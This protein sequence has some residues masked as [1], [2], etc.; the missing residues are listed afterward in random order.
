MQRADL[1]ITREW[2]RTIVWRLAMSQALL[3]SRSSKE[4]LSLLFPVRLS[5]NLRHQVTKMSRHDI[6]VHGSSMTQKLFEITDT[7]A[8]VLIHVPAASLEETALRIEDYLFILDFVLLFPTL[9][10]T[11]RGILLEK[12]ERLQSMFPEVCSQTSSPNMP[13]ELQN[14]HSAANDPWGQVAHSKMGSDSA[15]D[16]LALVALAPAPFADHSLPP[17]PPPPLSASTSSHGQHRDA[18][19]AR[20]NHISRRLSK[21]TFSVPA[22]LSYRT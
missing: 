11:R 21:A 6:E 12:L 17:P 20:W 16:P 1:A 13:L 15:P 8:D 10:H 4:C 19:Q 3:S 18:R 7:I 22:E 5:Q 9:D 14:P 2:L